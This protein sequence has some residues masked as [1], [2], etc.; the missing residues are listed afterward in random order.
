MRYADEL[1]KRPD[2]TLNVSTYLLSSLKTTVYH[3]LPATPSV[4]SLSLHTGVENNIYPQNVL[5]LYQIGLKLSLGTV[6]TSRQIRWSLNFRCKR[7]NDA[8]GKWGAKV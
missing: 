7:D 1:I 3:L 4:C 5:L 8:I 2:N 6:F